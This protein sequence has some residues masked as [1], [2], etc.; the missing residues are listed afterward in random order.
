ML[1]N[2]YLKKEALS[3]GF[4][5]HVVLYIKLHI[6]CVLSICLCYLYVIY[7]CVIYLYVTVNV[8]GALLQLCVSVFICMA[9]SSRYIEM[10]PCTYSV[11][12]VPLH[13]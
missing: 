4:Q 9:V 5:M 11:F 13:I 7:V 6:N 3:F 12:V 8:L 2:K 10:Y 1:N